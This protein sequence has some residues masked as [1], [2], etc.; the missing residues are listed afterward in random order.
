M[1]YGTQVD[2]PLQPVVLAT[3][4]KLV[5]KKNIRPALCHWNDSGI[6]ISIS[7]LGATPLVCKLVL[8]FFDMKKSSRYDFFE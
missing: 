8:K 2:D 1:V 4:S 7:R 6:T 5:V 3:V